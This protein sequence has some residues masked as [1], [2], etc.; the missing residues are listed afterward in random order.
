MG[1]SG[2]WN[3][4]YNAQRHYKSPFN[5]ICYTIPQAHPELSF[6]FK[7]PIF[8][9]IL[10]IALKSQ[11]NPIKE[12]LLYASFHF[13]LFASSNKLLPIFNIT[14]QLSVKMNLVLVALPCSFSCSSVIMFVI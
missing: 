14:M 6:M 9:S 2:A 1:S 8:T 7:L 5:I 10:Y 12:L 3:G 4:A 13:T 11:S